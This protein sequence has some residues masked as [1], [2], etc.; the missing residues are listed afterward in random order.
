MKSLRVLSPFLLVLVVFASPAFSYHA[1]NCVN[2]VWSDGYKP[3]GVST[4]FGGLSSE[5]IFEDFMPDVDMRIVKTPTDGGIK[6]D[7]PDKYRDRYEKW[8]TEFLSTDFGREQWDKYANNK[9]F[10]LTI[11][12]SNKKGKGGNG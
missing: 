6:E 10:I 9:Q 2:S 4:L 3:I 8:K 7:I 5:G 12:V 1:G 11:T